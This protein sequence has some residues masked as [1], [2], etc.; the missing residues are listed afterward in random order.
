M[1]GVGD[2]MTGKAWDCGRNTRLGCGTATG[3]KASHQNHGQ[4]AILVTTTSNDGCAPFIFETIPD[5][6]A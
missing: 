3:V 5:F 6:L 4:I 1:H 2:V